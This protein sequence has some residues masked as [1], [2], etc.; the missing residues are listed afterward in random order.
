MIKFAVFGRFAKGPSQSPLLPSTIIP[1]TAHICC[2][3]TR[4]G[5]HAL[6]ATPL[7]SGLLPVPDPVPAS[8]RA[9]ILPMD[10]VVFRAREF[11]TFD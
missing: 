1:A 8:E 3:Y 6:L 4:P 7:L 2:V 5:E 9:S 11:C 10:S